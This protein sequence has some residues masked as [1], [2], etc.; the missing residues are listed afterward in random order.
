MLTQSV[1]DRDAARD[2]GTDAAGL[3]NALAVFENFLGSGTHP[4]A[5]LTVRRHGRIVLQAAGGTTR[6]GNEGPAVTQQTPGVPVVRAQASA[7]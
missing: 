2:T 6:P 7:A 1:I 5:Q 3:E 4:G